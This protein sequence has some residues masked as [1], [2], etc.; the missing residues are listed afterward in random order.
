MRFACPQCHQRLEIKGNWPGNRL[1]CPKCGASIDLTA[2]LPSLL[3][4]NPLLPPRPRQP[5]HAP[6]APAAPEAGPEP[7]PESEPAARGGGLFWKILLFI[8]LLLAAAYVFLRGGAVAPHAAPASSPAVIPAAIPGQ[9]PAA[10]P[11]PAPSQ[12]AAAAT[13][14]VPAEDTESVL[15]NPFMGWV[16]YPAEN[17]NIP[18][19]RRYWLSQEA[20]A[21]LA[22][23]CYIR[24]LWS[25]ME[26]S[27]GA[28]AWETDANLKALIQGALDRGLRLAFRV[29]VTS[30]DVPL[31][32]TPEWVF[33]AGARV[34]TMDNDGKTP[35]VRDPV[36]QQKFGDFLRA[37]GKAFDDPARVNWV[38]AASIGWW[39]EMHH[40]DYLD[41]A[42]KPLVLQW[43]AN[44]YAA[45]FTHVPIAISF[46]NQL[47]TAQQM[48]DE[49]FS[50]G[51][52]AMRRDGVAGSFG[53]VSAQ[54]AQEITQRWPG[55]PFIAEG[56][57]QA[58]TADQMR[59]TVEQALALHANFLDLRTPVPADNWVKNH[60][61]LVREFNL[62]GG[63]RFVIDSVG[64]PREFNSGAA[65][66]ITSK[67]RNVG[68]GILPNNLKCW[69]W[70]YK[71][72]FALL[73]P[74]G[75]QPVGILVDM[76]KADDPWTWENGRAATTSVNGSFG[77]VPPGD[78]DLAVGVV[79]TSDN[80][81]AE[82]QLAITAPRT[83]TGWYRW[84]AVTVRKVAAL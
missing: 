34:A 26:P 58:P 82:I 44:A 3:P 75:D 57:Y 1:D 78:Y 10:F 16:L 13:R 22:S 9:S 60:P 69:N 84:G 74:I 37:F 47:A 27:E 32:A 15:R 42:S 71:L 28:Y 35:D 33:Q 12:A 21:R 70:K 8:L 40:L 67:I 11:S 73:N 19:A 54:Q 20:N 81:K 29:Y 45:A 55:M 38:D 52:F 2:P 39:G 77:N 31:Q 46:P 30:R 43:L 17:G 51:M 76:A 6:T 23:T 7:D 4:G 24:I 80:N 61:G 36:F 59:A 79:D 18:N 14:S 49:C 41:A 56:Y 62:R 5:A 83:A 50:K 48:D 65:I 53:D 72:A 64:Y 68:V 66:A 63:Y 25:E